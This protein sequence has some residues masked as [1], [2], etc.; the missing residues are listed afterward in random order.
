MPTPL[1]LSS[2]HKDL[3]LSTAR[4]TP[5]GYLRRNAVPCVDD[6]SEFDI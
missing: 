2:R 4:Q 6:F 1:S 3:I 5:H